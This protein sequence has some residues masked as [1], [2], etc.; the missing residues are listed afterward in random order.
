MKKTTTKRKESI[1]AILSMRRAPGQ[2]GN[3]PKATIYDPEFVKRYKASRRT[4][5]YLKQKTKNK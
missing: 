3:G 4:K 1:L 5:A 2:K